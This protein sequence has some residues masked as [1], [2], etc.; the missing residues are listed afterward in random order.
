MHNVIYIDEYRANRQAKAD[1]LTK[2]GPVKPLPSPQRIW[3]LLDRNIS[4]D[5]WK[6]NS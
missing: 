5:V 4:I 6:K 3:E 1:K 2:A